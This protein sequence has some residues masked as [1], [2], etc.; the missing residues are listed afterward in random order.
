VPFAFDGTAVFFVGFVLSLAALIAVGSM[1]RRGRP[2]PT[3][4]SLAGLIAVGIG[5]HNFG[6]GLAI[7]AAYSLGEVALTSLLIVGFAIHNSTEG[8]AIVAPL[9]TS[10]PSL[11]LLAILGIL[12]G[13]PTIAGTWLGAFAYSPMVAILFLG[14]GVGAIAQVVWEVL[15]LIHRRG[16]LGHPLNVAGVVAGVLTMY[17]TA[18][19]VS[20]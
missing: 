4:V 3:A 1:L 11:A 13:A 14:L 12:A 9:S 7:S 15:R 2:R 18:L 10:R 20:M 5:L 6:E 17:L 16:D 19:I 8:V